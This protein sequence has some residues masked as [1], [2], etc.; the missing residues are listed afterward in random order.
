MTT[1]QTRGETETVANKTPARS[2][3]NKRLK[4][5][6]GR[7]LLDAVMYRGGPLP[8]PCPP[9]YRPR[10]GYSSSN[11]RWRGTKPAY[12]LPLTR[13]VLNLST[14]RPS[15]DRPT[16]RATVHSFVSRFSLLPPPLDSSPLP[17]PPIA[18]T[19][20]SSRSINI[21]TRRERRRGGRSSL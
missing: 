15:T 20:P 1:S 14:G 6:V 8:P 17:N 21:P 10:R 7:K 19:A 11:R 13:L 4:S 16:D 2:Y 12:N 3:K 9:K 18:R 5:F